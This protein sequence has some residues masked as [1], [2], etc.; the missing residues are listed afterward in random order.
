MSVNN[1]NDTKFFF[2]SFFSTPKIA[3]LRLIVITIGIIVFLSI[4]ISNPKLNT[5]AQLQQQTQPNIKAANVYQTQTMVLGNNI[6]NLV[7]LIPNEAHEPPN[8]K[9]KE[10]RVV[11][12]PYLPENAVVNVGTTVTW[13]NAD[14]K[15]PHKITLVDS[16]SKNIVFESDTFEYF[17][18]S[19]PIKFNNT[20]TFTYSGPSFDK[21]FPK[22]IMNG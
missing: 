3:K 11:N 1:K 19:K 16:K 14:V 10:L 21:A 7:I 17:T 6:K 15:H 5:N 12:Q 20:G 2:F 4:A 18:A 8:L 9:P 13:F 22:Y